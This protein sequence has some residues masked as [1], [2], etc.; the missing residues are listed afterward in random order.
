MKNQVNT[1]TT[2]NMED[3]IKSEI[4]EYIRQQRQIANYNH[5][6]CINVI[7]NL[8][9]NLINN[10]EKTIVSFLE[11]VELAEVP[12]DVETDE[13]INYCYIFD[14]YYREIRSICSDYI[15]S[16][17]EEVTGIESTNKEEEKT[18]NIEAAKEL[19]IEKVVAEMRNY[20]D[21]HFK[22]EFGVTESI[23]RY[24][25]NALI[26]EITYTIYHK[27]I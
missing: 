26:D 11:E 23:T 13:K 24:N 16:K 15:N 19:I 9:Q 8:F 6:V 10:P 7:N 25:F 4:A 21:F 2:N 1:T 14:N 22:S 12:G 27:T 17:F 18:V 20:R 3:K 5:R